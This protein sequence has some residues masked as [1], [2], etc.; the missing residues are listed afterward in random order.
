MIPCVGLN[1][2]MR[3]NRWKRVTTQQWNVSG[4]HNVYLSRFDFFINILN[5]TF[6]SFWRNFASES[7]L[8]ESRTRTESLSSTLHPAVYREYCVH[9]SSDHL[10]VKGT[11]LVRSWA[12]EHCWA[13]EHGPSPTVASKQSRSFLI[14]K[15]SG[16]KRTAVAKN[17][18]VTIL[19]GCLHPD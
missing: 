4:D 18:N 6:C 10:V 11:G 1:I 9:D 3:R 15:S 13:P 5:S 14:V 12:P 2:I 19:I 7:N 16:Y 8:S 17:V